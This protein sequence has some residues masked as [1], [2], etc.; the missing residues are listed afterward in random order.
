[1]ARN[2]IQESELHSSMVSRD[3]ITQLT[4]HLLITRGVV[5]NDFPSHVAS[6]YLITYLRTWL[7]NIRHIRIRI[8]TYVPSLKYDHI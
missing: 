3:R 6:Y 5:I 1:M 7:A 2:E 8:F 4:N